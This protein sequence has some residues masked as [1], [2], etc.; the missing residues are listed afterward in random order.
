MTVIVEIMEERLFHT[1]KM[2]VI[3]EEEMLLLTTEIIRTK[4]N[5]QKIM[6]LINFLDHI[7]LNSLYYLRT[8][9]HIS[10]NLIIIMIFGSFIRSK[11]VYYS[12]FVKF[13][14]TLI[15]VQETPSMMSKKLIFN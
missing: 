5:L 11:S 7:N 13:A 9:L 15:K 3:K 10:I 4:E 6:V 8:I 2:L 1:E 12:S 14:N